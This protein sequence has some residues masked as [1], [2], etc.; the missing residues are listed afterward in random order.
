M[1]KKD[2]KNKA[3]SILAALIFPAII[4]GIVAA[5][6][7]NW[8]AIWSLFESPEVLRDWIEEQGP[9][10][11]IVFIVIQFIQVA[12]FIIPGEVPQIAG[13]YLF[14]T[15]LGVVYSVIGIA[16]GSLFNFFLARLLGVHFVKT[17]FGE[18]E[19]K[20][21][22][23]I[24]SSPR[25]R[26]AFFFLFVIP[27]LP[28]DALCYVAG[29]TNMSFLTFFAISSIGRLPAIIGSAI[30]G[31]SAAVHNWSLVIGIGIAAVV[32]F[33]AGLIFRNQIHD[34]IENFTTKENTDIKEEEPKTTEK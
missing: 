17:L 32:L 30:I 5:V 14:G 3:L 10:A 25:A 7:F 20:K 1:E 4:L 16:I 2:K 28:K 13:G 6:F 18:N 9:M 12:I 21:F 31:D 29:L 34:I 19:L 8:D 27:G 11:P 23:N 15:F 33:A 26:I 24:T 22:E